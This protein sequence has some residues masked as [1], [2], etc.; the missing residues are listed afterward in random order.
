MYDIKNEEEGELFLAQ[1][2]FKRTYYPWIVQHTDP[3]ILRQAVNSFATLLQ[4]EISAQTSKACFVEVLQPVQVPQQVAM[5]EKRECDI[6][7]MNP[8][9]F[10]F[11]H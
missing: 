4:H 9:G 7:L 11:A 1:I 2:T 5:I 8:L 10:V 6:A 3:M